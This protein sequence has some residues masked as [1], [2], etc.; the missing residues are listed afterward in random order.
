MIAAS[1]AEGAGRYREL[2]CKRLERNSIPCPATGCRLWLGGLNERGYGR[3][4]VGGLMLKAHRVSWC[5]ANGPI[6]DGLEIR[7]KCDV[8]ACIE[9]CHLVPGT[10]EENMDD[11]RTRGLLYSTSSKLTVADVMHIRSYDGPCWVL[12]QRFGVSECAIAD[13]L[14]GRTWSMLPGARGSIETRG[15]RNGASRLSAQD[16]RFAR[17]S[18]QPIAALARQFGV[19][20]KTMREAIQGR[21]WRHVQ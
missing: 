15:E 9:V 12:A 6:P 4:K 19:D 7:H 8:R 18:D 2:L 1:P 17:A 10:H 13:A 20:R 14:T 16:V 21:T 11:V 3:I 5:L